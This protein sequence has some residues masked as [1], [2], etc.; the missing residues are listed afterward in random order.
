MV[1]NVV[2]M[3]SGQVSLTTARPIN[4]A[5]PRTTVNSARPMT[6][7]FNKAHSTVRMPINKNIAFKNS[8]FNKRVNTVNNK[9]VNAARPKAVVN[10]ARPKAVLNAVK[11]NQV[12]VV[13]QD[14]Q[15]K[16]VIDSGC[17]RHITGNMSYLTDFEEIDG[18]YVAF[19]GSGP[20]W[21]FDID[22]LT[23]S[24]NY[25]LVVTGNQFNG[26]A[27]IKACDDTSK[28]R[29]EIV[30][31]KDY[32]LLPLWTTDPPFSQSLKSSPDVGFKPLGNDEKKVTEEPGKEG[33]DPSKEGECNDQEKEDN[34]KSTNNVNA[35]STNK[36]NAVGVKTSIELPNDLNMI[37]LEDIVYSDDNEDVG[38][39]ADMNNLDAFM[40]VIPI[41]TTRIHKYH[42]VEQI[43]RDLNSAPQTRRMTKNLEEMSCLV[44]FSS[45]DKHKYYSNCFV[46]LLFITR[47]TQKVNSCIEGSKLDRGYAGRA[48][49]IQLQ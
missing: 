32:I 35:A 12:N 4:T 24:L 15:K 3:R 49:T 46:L 21:L 48:S 7:V 25:K 11:G 8:N 44:L 30:P 39:E 18:G 16:G 42:L 34:V 40:P 2:L 23:K 33:G 45:A 6:N 41:L 17:S 9:N 37:E 10:D 26:N 47:R 5:Q 14:L 19:G 31:G 22:A 36:V 13:K 28:A 20:N 29:M 1:P 43:I 38:A 27:G